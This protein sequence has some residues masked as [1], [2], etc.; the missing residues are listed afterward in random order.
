MNE[1]RTAPHAITP[2]AVF[3]IRLPKSPLMAK[4]AAGN[5]GM[6]QMRSRK[7]MR[8]PLHQVDFVDVH[9]FLVLEHGDDDAE[10]NGRLSSGD[11]DHEDREYL[12]R[13]MTE[14]ARERDEVDID[15]V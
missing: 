15:G 11:G 13:H 12:P 4:P 1:S 5:S 14:S 7:F 9:C 2:T 8:L 10:A 6:S 3:G